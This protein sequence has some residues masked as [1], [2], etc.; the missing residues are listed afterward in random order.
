MSVGK[1]KGLVIHGPPV[2]GKSQVI[3]N[4][5]SNAIAKD[6]KVPVVC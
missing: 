3:V 5:I 2:T 1:A 4:L 6:Q